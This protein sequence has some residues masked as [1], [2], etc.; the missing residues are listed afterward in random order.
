MNLDAFIDGLPDLTQ[1]VDPELQ[2]AIAAA[3]KNPRL[4]QG[5][6]PTYYNNRETRSPLDILQAEAAS[7]AKP[8]TNMLDAAVDA[9]P[10]LKGAPAANA[11]ANLGGTLQLGIPWTNMRFDTK[12][13]L[14][15]SVEAGIIG[16]GHAATR[17]VQGVQQPFSGDNMKAQVAAED[18][19]YKPL[20]QAHPLATGI[21]EAVPYLA[22]SNPLTMAAMGATSYGTPGERATA[23]G[24]GYV[25]GKIG[26]GIGRMF[27][28]ESMRAAPSEVGDFVQSAGN[29][30]GIPTTV[31]QQPDASRTAQ[32]AESVLSNLPFGGA[33]NKAR[34]ASFQGFNNAVSGTIGESSSQ[35]TPDLLGNAQKRIVGVINNIADRSK[36][37]ANSPAFLDGMTR[38]EALMNE[39][40]PVGSSDR[41]TAQHWLDQVMANVDKDGTIAGQTY[42]HMRSSLGETMQNAGNATPVLGSIRDAL[43]KG[44]DA[45]IAPKDMQAWMTANKQY[46]NLQQIADATK[47]TPGSLSPSSLL[48]QVNAAQRGARFGG[49]NDLAEL[50]QWAKTTLP[51]KIPNSGTAQRQYIQAMLTNPGKTIAGAGLLGGAGYAG[52][53]YLSPWDASAALVPLL[54]G[55]GLAGRPVSDVTKRLLM[56]G[57]GL[58]GLNAGS[59]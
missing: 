14:P 5:I 26:Q 24:L 56:Q 42:R 18:A 39:R 4:Q 41:A 15:A 25:G 53:D 58:L 59:Q 17:L 10:A 8:K 3:Q 2:Q 43:T 36:L 44:M 27:G 37:D 47:A 51:D 21:G 55:R 54:V 1:G 49:G 6:K 12:I 52:S 48:T 46:F 22:A 40:L 20:E 33:V 57:G 19:A 23:G 16:A 50:A 35:I 32:I 30:W 31:A 29:K 45:S 38:A 34:N 9:M 13:P 7:Q 11:D 28:P